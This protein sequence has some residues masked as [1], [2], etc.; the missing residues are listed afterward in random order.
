MSQT[1]NNTGGTAPTE[2]LILPGE[3]RTPMRVAEDGNSVEAPFTEASPNAPEAPPAPLAPLVGGKYKTVE[4]LE[5][6]YRELEAKLGAPK[7]ED[8]PKPEDEELPPLPEIDPDAPKVADIEVTDAAREELKEKGLDIDHFTR[9]FGATGT[10]SEASYARLEKAGIPRDIVNAYIDGQKRFVD[11]QIREVKD[12]VGGEETYAR[13]HQWAGTGLSEPEK[14][15]YNRMFETHDLTVC[16]AAALSLKARYEAALGKDPALQ[17]NGGVGGGN[18]GVWR[19]ESAA[20]M[21]EAMRDPRYA[22]DP[23]Y[24]ARVE[25]KVANSN[26]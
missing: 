17:V 4:E 24:R 13:I 2:S 10:L 3:A 1:A 11:S 23:A 21:V 16:K 15:A 25:R 20:Q 19:F 5:K 26:F 7:E 14:I 9:E 8:Q 22:S 6:A 12:S 18:D